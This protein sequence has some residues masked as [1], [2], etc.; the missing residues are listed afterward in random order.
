MVG[1]FAACMVVVVVGVRALEGAI[2][3]RGRKPSA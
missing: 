2:G 3:K 1:I